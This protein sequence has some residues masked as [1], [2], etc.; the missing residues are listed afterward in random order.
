M[1]AR[2]ALLGRLIDHAP[3]FP[4]AQLPLDEALADHDAA[5]ASDAAWMVNRFVVRASQFAP[6]LPKRLSVV[7]D[8]AIPDDPRIEAVELPPEGIVPFGDSPGDSP[9]DS[10]GAAPRLKRLAA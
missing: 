1:D 8:A 4:P 7:A 3:M 10:P 6:E 5:R 9:V 2:R